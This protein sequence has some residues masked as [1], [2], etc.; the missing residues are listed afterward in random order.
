MKKL[1]FSNKLWNTTISELTSLSNTQISNNF[2]TLEEITEDLNLLITNYKN[3][4]EYFEKQNKEL[5][6]LYQE[7]KDL[8]NLFN[9]SMAMYRKELKSK[10]VRNKIFN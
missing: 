6:N 10:Q 5:I 4:I 7:Y 9:M 3:D 8:K 1:D 2:S